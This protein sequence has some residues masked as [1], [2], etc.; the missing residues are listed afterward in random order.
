MIFNEL[1]GQLES[2]FFEFENYSNR[3]DEI[4]LTL[5]DLDKELKNLEELSRQMQVKHLNKKLLIINK[6]V[7]FWKIY[8][9][10]D[11]LIKKL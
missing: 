5:E 2:L 8:R 3:K 1:A 4:E 9:N 10:F 7:Y 11:F 6:K